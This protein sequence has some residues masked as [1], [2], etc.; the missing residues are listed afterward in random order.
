MLKLTITTRL[1]GI[2]LASM[3]VISCDCGRGDS[4]RKRKEA[5][6]TKKLVDEQKKLV[7]DFK[8]KYKLTPDQANK[9][10]E[11]L[12]EEK[13]KGKVDID[14]SI[15]DFQ[16]TVDKVSIRGTA[17][18]QSIQVMMD[19]FNQQLQEQGLPLLEDMNSLKTF[20]LVTTNSNIQ[21]FVPGFSI[22]NFDQIKPILTGLIAIL[23]NIKKQ[24]ELGIKNRKVF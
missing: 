3:L 15:K 11:K 18:P 1:I 23:E 19:S 5:A 8:Q 20:I 10:E 6:E 2:L 9:F 21:K 14:A 16:D 7:E 22:P 17:D 13:N 4:D 12:T 24:V